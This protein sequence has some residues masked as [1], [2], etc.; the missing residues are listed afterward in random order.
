VHVAARLG[1]QA[2]KD[3]GPWSGAGKYRAGDRAKFL[4]G[5]WNLWIRVAL[6]RRLFRSQGRLPFCGKVG[7]K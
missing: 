1:T 2:A 3:G 5:T 6:A 4:L 7:A